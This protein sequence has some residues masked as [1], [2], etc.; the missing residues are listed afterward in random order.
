MNEEARVEAENKGV[1]WILT[2]IT[3]NSE[4]T[5]RDFVENGLK[6]AEKTIKKLPLMGQP[7]GVIKNEKNIT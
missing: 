1:S 2:G 7:G 4:Y 5:Y 6:K 3:D